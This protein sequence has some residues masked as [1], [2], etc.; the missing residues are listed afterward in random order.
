[1]FKTSM[2][3]LNPCS[4]PVYEEYKF[5]KQAGFDSVMLGWRDDNRKEKPDKARNAGL[6]I[7]NIHAPFKNEDSIWFDNLNGDDYMECLL[8]SINDCREH[9]IPTMVVHLCNTNNGPPPN[10]TG[11]ERLKQIAEKAE[12][13]N[14]NIAFENGYA[15]EHIH[16][17]LNNIPSKRF[18]FCFDS[19][20]QNYMT[21]DR[22]LLEE[23]ENHVMALH[24]SDGFGIPENIIHEKGTIEWIRQ[25]DVHLLPFDGNID[26]DKITRQLKTIQ[27][28]GA[29]AFEVHSCKDKY[30]P[31]EFYM[32]A[33]NRADKLL[34]M[35]D[36]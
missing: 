21:P 31:E 12:H 34:G 30:T 5:M 17:V 14:I 27:Y 15:P 9:N 4:L 26:W 24:L 19:C 18:G 36:I 20:H 13:D 11:I 10:N 32:E 1:M 22:D 8:T 28:K 6:L 29:I 3:D 33:F 25:V 35:V 2:F 23:F 7:E 16:F